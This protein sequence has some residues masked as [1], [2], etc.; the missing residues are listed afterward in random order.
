MKFGNKLVILWLHFGYHRIG[1]LIREE[2]TRAKQVE[3][4]TCLGKTVIV[5]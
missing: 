5:S 1:R 2:C 3:N 4:P